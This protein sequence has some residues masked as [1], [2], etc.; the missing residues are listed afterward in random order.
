MWL[1]T[2]RRCWHGG[3]GG[4][5]LVLSL[6]VGAG[7]GLAAGSV[8]D[9]G[10]GAP[11]ADE[12]A[13]P[14]AGAADGGEATD[15]P[16]DAPADKD[17]DRPRRGV[18]FSDRWLGT[19]ALDQLERAATGNRLAE[20]RDQMREAIFGRLS[21][22]R[23]EDL[24][25]LT[26]MVYVLRACEYLPQTRDR[27]FA[28]WLLARRAVARLLFRAIQDYGSA[29]E[30][31]ER[32]HTLYKHDAEAV[33]QY[34]D[35]AV[36]FATTRPLPAPPSDEPLKRASMLES[37]RWYTEGDV[38][39]R[40]NLRRLP[41]EMARFLADT[42]L[43]L[44]E[45]AWAVRA[46]SD[47]RKPAGLFH[48]IA[49]D[50]DH[51][52]RNVP[53]RIS[54]VAYTLPNLAT[55]GG[56]CAE[57]AYFASEVCK[58]LGLPAARVTGRGETGVGH[59]WVACLRAAGGHARWDST[60]GRYEHHRYYTGT[61]RDPVSGRDLYDTD[62]MLATLAAQLPLAR[63]E[64]AD[65]ATELARRVFHWRGGATTN[66]LLRLGMLYN[67]R[68]AEGNRP[69]AAVGWVRP[70]RE[71]D[72]AMVVDL[73]AAALDRNLAHRAAWDFLLERAAD[74]TLSTEQAG[75][76]LDVLVRRTRRQ[77]PEY[78][79]DMVLRLAAQVS[80]VAERMEL[81]E[82]CARA[83][84]RADLR[85]RICLEVANLHRQ[86][87][88]LDKAVRAYAKTARQ[89]ANIPTVVL[90]AADAAEKLLRDANEIDAA[91]RMYEGLLRRADK[92]DS[93]QMS[94]VRGSTHWQ[95]GMRLMRLHKLQGNDEAAA[96]AGRKISP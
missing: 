42:R 96:K 80:D 5:A 48:E 9:T 19:I 10:A 62:V 1:L 81:Y 71:L 95:I 59:A 24:G 53:K 49:Y 65:A 83:F 60:T 14:K 27:E 72:T 75:R 46:Y 31:L 58:A 54:R 86:Q 7:T 67:A 78:T 21:C 29:R 23:L 91:I 93:E 34:P 26:D 47:E 70:Q 45:R 79:C 64:E 22:G 3:M 87:N 11:T 56:V 41:F 61:L 36:A 37:W 85:G 8:P 32:L 52:E 90:P 50:S 69:K 92:V 4:L 74:G 51:V 89:C 15:G 40:C 66:E 57:Q 84:R 43:S 18:R 76:F 25:A 2:D 68:F 35:L 38:A 13:A 94:V 44:E 20:L 6:A 63:Q 82:R 12:N 16:S 39:F 17:D 30:P 88:D 77:Y 33:A 28:G 55:Y 73:L